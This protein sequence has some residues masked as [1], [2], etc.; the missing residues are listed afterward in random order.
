MREDNP[1]SVRSGNGRVDDGHILGSD[2]KGLSPCPSNGF[3]GGPVMEP[4]A[5]NLVF[6]P[7][8]AIFSM[9][10]VEPMQSVSNGVAACS[11]NGYAAAPETGNITR[12]LI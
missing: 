4:E 1:S 12:L 5:N 10:S 8:E 7:I 2:S 9:T 6:D 3:G 11:S